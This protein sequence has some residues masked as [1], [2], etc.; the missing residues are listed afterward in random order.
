MLVSG[1][2]VNCSTPP[3][4]LTEEILNQIVVGKQM[5]VID[6]QCRYWDILG[7]EQVV[8]K[9]GLAIEWT[10]ARALIRYQDYHREKTKPQN[11]N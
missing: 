8:Y 5:V 3:A 6:G 4:R 11:P 10:T 9:F 1:G 2:K 7:D